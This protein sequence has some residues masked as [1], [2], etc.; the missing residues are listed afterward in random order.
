VE[1]QQ[2]VMGWDEFHS[3]TRSAEYMEDEMGYLSGIDGWR[4]NIDPELK[5]ES[6][7]GMWSE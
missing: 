3:P 1:K 5:V 7:F 2:G 4:F 6:G